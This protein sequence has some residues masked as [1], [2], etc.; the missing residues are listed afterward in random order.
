MCHAVGSPLTIYWNVEHGQSVG[1]TLPSFLRWNSD[2][3][4]DK[5]NALLDAMGV[6]NLDQ[7]ESKLS[8][9]L[10]NCGLETRLSGLGLVRNDIETLTENIKC[11]LASRLPRSFDKNDAR[12]LLEEIF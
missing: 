4:S 8:S 7:A 11:E 12:S 2:A 1:I 5:M 3:I 6:A 10:E 9:M